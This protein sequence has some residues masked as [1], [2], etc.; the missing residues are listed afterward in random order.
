MQNKA[1][2]SALVTIALALTS[3]SAFAQGGGQ[4]GGQADRASQVDRDHTYDRDR[5]QDRDLLDVSDRDRDRDRDRLQV[6]DYSQLKD[7]EIYGSQLMSAEERNLY[8]EQLQNAATAREREQIQAEHHEQM[9]ARAD[10]QGLD[11]VPPGQGPI[12]GG[13]VMTVQE[14]NE[15]REQLRLIE[16]DQEREQLIAKHREEVQ[17]RAKR[18]GVELEEIVEA[19]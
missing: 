9:Q 14:R 6:Q 12:Y 16:S 1:S 3:L 8:R 15:Y 10:E 18:R 19:D 5:Q 13:N 11:L 4:S 17:A 2:I 7:R